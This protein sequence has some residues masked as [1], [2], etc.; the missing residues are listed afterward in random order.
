MKNLMNS[1]TLMGHVGVNPEV[2]IFKNGRKMATLSL[3][4]GERKKGPDGKFARSVTWHKLVGWGKNADLMEN[5]VGKGQRLMIEGRLV[6]RSWQGRHGKNYSSTRVEVNKL[7][8]LNLQN[9][10]EA[11]TEDL[12]F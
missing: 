3:A 12:P 5:H 2:R 9:K 7:Y 8:F 1:V 11:V 6:K 10:K 4:T